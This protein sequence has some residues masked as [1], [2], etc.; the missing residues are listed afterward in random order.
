L[1]GD[2]GSV[3][4]VVAAVAG[5]GETGDWT[6]AGSGGSVDGEVEEADSFCRFCD[7]GDL[8]KLLVYH[9]VLPEAIM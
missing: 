3:E 2:G 4:R 8:V 1:G 5:E 9:R 6:A 7:G